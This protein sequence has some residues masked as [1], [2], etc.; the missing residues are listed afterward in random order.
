MSRKPE[1]TF[2][3]KFTRPELDALVRLCTTRDTY[4]DSARNTA[5]DAAVAKLRAAIAAS[6]VK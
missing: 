4:Q 2:V 3:V 6:E 1:P 5:D